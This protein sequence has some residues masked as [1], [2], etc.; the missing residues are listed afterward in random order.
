MYQGWLHSALGQTE[1]AEAS[2]EAA[3]RLL[4]AQLEERPDDYR[5]HYSLALVY[6]GLGRDEEAIFHGKQNITLL[7]V[8][9]DA[10]EGPNRLWGLA[11]VYAQVGDAEAAAATL[12]QVFSLQSQFSVAFT[13]ADFFF[14][15]IR[16]HPSYQSVI[17]KYR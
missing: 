14:D 17:E 4:E 16:D 3:R 1:L 15:P 2:F 12:E 7:P 9:E 10:V 5:V 6:A 13:E 8:S 11:S